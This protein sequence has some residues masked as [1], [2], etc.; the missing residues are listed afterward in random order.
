MNLTHKYIR[1]AI[2]QAKVIFE[3]RNKDSGYSL[4]QGSKHRA[5]DEGRESAGMR[6]TCFLVWMPIT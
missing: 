2:K 6:M 4:G 5:W 3:D 1:K